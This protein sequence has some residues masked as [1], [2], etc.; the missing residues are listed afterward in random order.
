MASLYR[1][2]IACD[3][4]SAMEESERASRPF[5]RGILDAFIYDWSN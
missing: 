4:E 5:L 1:S 3:L 2:A